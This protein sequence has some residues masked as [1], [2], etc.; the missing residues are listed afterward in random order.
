MPANMTSR[1]ALSLSERNAL[2]Q[3]LGRIT[4]DIE[5]VQNLLT[6]AAA[7]QS[8]TPSEWSEAQL[9]ALTDA[10]RKLGNAAERVPLIGD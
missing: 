6:V 4:D 1:Y 9:D 2:R 8:T 5:R 10:V 7:R 3:A